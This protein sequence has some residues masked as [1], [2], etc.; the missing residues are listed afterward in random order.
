M[1]AGKLG[2][3]IDISYLTPERAGG[4]G[5]QGGLLGPRGV[6]N[7]KSN[8]WIAKNESERERGAA[9]LLGL[10]LLCFV[11]WDGNCVQ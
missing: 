8:T 6:M 4:T 10:V 11:K 5:W 1:I 7:T 2:L 9:N 3:L